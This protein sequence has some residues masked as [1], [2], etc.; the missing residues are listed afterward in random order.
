MN[1][2]S[3]ENL[4][5]KQLTSNYLYSKGIPFFN[6]TDEHA[7][8]NS[9]LVQ[10]NVSLIELTF[11]FRLRNYLGVTNFSVLNLWATTRIWIVQIF[12]WRTLIDIGKSLFFMN[13]IF[14]SLTYLLLLCSVVDSSLI[15]SVKC[16]LITSHFPF[17]TRCIPIRL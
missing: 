3:L 14:M 7:F 10:P 17:R 5:D 9:I 2:Y 12:T 4:K 11:S 15:I 16:N 1:R 13:T 6:G 8:F